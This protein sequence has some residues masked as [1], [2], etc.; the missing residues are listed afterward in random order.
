MFYVNI[1]AITGVSA[2]AGACD[3][4]EVW[5]HVPVTCVVR[6]LAVVILGLYSPGHH[7]ANDCGRDLNSSIENFNAAALLG[8]IML[9]MFV[10]ISDD[11]SVARQPYSWWLLTGCRCFHMVNSN[12]HL[13]LLNK[14]QYAQHYSHLSPNIRLR[15]NSFQVCRKRF[16]EKNLKEATYT[17]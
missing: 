8:T 13:I 12:S 10:E 1:S 11:C 7:C 17:F 9:A 6:V 5:L 16:R 2:K 4:H 14:C 15:M 3:V